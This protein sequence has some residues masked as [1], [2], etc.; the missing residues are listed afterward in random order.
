MRRYNTVLA[1]LASAVFLLAAAYFTT[2]VLLVGA[3]KPPA[4]LLPSLI[5]V[6]LIV[7]YSVKFA[8]AKRWV[9]SAHFL[10]LASCVSLVGALGVDLFFLVSDHSL[11]PPGS[12]LWSVGWVISGVLLIAN[13]VSAETSLEG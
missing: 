11:I 7:F 3:P 2:K 4:S 1:S 6:F 10:F 5:C 13:I 12:A 9:W 8:N